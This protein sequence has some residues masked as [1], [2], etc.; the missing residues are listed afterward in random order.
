MN[1]TETEESPL[2]NKIADF[3]IA[4]KLSIPQLA[5]KAGISAQLVH[6]IETGRTIPRVG[7]AVKIC[8]A[9]EQN[10]DKVFPE[11]KSILKAALKEGNAMAA[12]SDRR[13]AGAM[14]EAGL[15]TEPA[16]CSLVYWLRGG[17]SGILSVSGVTY[18]ALP[19]D[20]CR[21]DPTDP[22]L[23]FDTEQMKVMIRL[24]HLLCTHLLFDAPRPNPT[25]EDEDLGNVVV[26]LASTPEP[27]FFEVEGDLALAHGP[28]SKKMEPIDTQMQRL[29]TTIGLTDDPAR[30]VSFV[31]ANGE[32]VF[33]RLGDVAMIQ[34]P[35][36]ALDPGWSFFDDDQL[37]DDGD[38]VEVEATRDQDR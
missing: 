14:I 2:L 1:M 37:E 16:L 23:V 26:H 17:S 4:K 30:V 7:V 19:S 27:L 35:H 10:L 28:S 22:Y 32:Q 6:E 20:L 33:L 29:L 3:R 25:E 15:D 31:D 36:W 12:L 9:L 13:Y 18:R 34:I 38:G 21:A 5:E 8:A 24:D 11:T